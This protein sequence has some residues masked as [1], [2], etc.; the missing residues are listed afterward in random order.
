[1]RQI[2]VRGGAPSVAEEVRR[3]LAPLRG[4]S[5]VSL[6]P[7]RVER[8]VNALSTVARATYDRAFPNTLVVFVVPEQP[9]A[10][11]RRGS[12]S[13]LV[14]ARGRVIR[15]LPRRARLELPRVWLA[16]DVPLSLGGLVTD[17]HALRALRALLPLRQLRVPRVR[18]LRSGP[19]ELT[20]VLARGD[21]IRLGDE[22]AL[23]LKLAVAERVLATA[24]GRFA[25]LDVTLPQRPVARESLKS[26]LEVDG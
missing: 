26:Q 2:E 16:R 4:T 19:G 25:Y 12:E 24:R 20:L 15:T 7:E 23:R 21:E 11:F 1:M 3:S 6:R 17:A 8:R 5:L 13:W 22:S 10:V 9:V 18:S 14:S